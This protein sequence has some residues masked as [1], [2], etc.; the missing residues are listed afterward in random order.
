VDR[1]SPIRGGI[2]SDHERNDTGS[3]G[4]PDGRGGGV[5]RAVISIFPSIYKKKNI[6]I[7]QQSEILIL[8]PRKFVIEEAEEMKRNAKRTV[9]VEKG[10]RGR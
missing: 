8:T 9:K 6:K 10:E 1:S 4:D 2:G 3:R 7:N 5:T